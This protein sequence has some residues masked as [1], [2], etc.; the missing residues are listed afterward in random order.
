MNVNSLHKRIGLRDLSLDFIFDEQ[1]DV[2]KQA[3]GWWD[4]MKALGGIVRVNW[5]EPPGEDP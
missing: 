1:G 4:A 3:V 5:L 2:G